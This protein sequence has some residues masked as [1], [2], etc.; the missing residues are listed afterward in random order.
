MEDNKLKQA[1]KLS[2]ANQQNEVK[3]Q[4]SLFK[5]HNNEPNKNKPYEEADDFAFQAN[6]IVISNSS[7]RNN[8]MNSEGTSRKK[9]NKLHCN[10]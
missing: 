6:N 10:S 8:Q 9:G 7:M 1:L 5:N 3:N 2:K 4:I